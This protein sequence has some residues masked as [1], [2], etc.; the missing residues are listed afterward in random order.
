MSSLRDRGLSAL[1]DGWRSLDHEAQST[2][3]VRADHLR[4]SDVNVLVYGDERYPAAIASADS[5]PPF[6]Y[7]IGNLDIL[8]RRNVGM[9]GSREASARGL[10]AA[11]TCGEEVAAHDFNVVSG[12][13]RGVDMETH[14]AALRSGGCTVIVLAEGISHFRVKRALKDLADWNRM[15][16]L[17]QFPP[18][19]TWTAGAAMTR[20]GVIVGLAEALVVI[21][22]SERGGTLNAGERAL[23]AGKPVVALQFSEGTPAGNRIL[24]EAG[25]SP[26]SR[27][28]DLASY[29]DGLTEESV[30][31]G[32][33]GSLLD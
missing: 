24:F 8:A 18:T 10:E 1:E 21:E 3:R 23:K 5:P 15:L 13:A 19:Q 33:Q 20:N 7:Y 16:V 14:L 29:L 27:R 11:R 2:A 30:R 4:Q 6:L 31:E 28:T 25:A 26:L 32:G 9:C 12:Y 17:S 22:A